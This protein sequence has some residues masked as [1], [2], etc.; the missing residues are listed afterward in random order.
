M[1]RAVR[2]LG[3]PGKESHACGGTVR[4]GI[5]A[6]LR[7]VVQS[8]RNYVSFRGVR[9]VRRGS[10][11]A[12]WTSRGTV[13][14]TERAAAGLGEGG[15]RSRHRHWLAPWLV[16]GACGARDIGGT[17]ESLIPI[18]VSS[19]TASD[20][21]TPGSCQRDDDCRAA[22][23]CVAFS[24]VAGA[25]EARTLSCDDG[26]PCTEDT[27]DP[28]TGCHH[29]LLTEDLDGDG[30]RGPLAGMAAGVPGSCGD[31][32]DDRSS[33]TYPGAPELCDG[34]DND[35]NGIAD[36]GR[37]LALQGDEPLWLSSDS[38][39]AA[40]S[41]ITH[42]GKQFVVALS[43]YR[44][45]NE[46]ELVAVA[47][48]QVN[49]RSAAVRTNSDSYPGSI[50]WTGQHLALAWE[51]RR[52][53]DFEIYFNRFDTAGQKLGPDQRLSHARGFSLAPDLL[54][55]GEGYFVA[56][57][58]RRLGADDFRVFGQTVEL[59]GLRSGEQNA[60]LTP[61]TPGASD[62]RLARG[63]TTSG[64]L[65]HRTEV[66]GGQ[67]LFQMLDEELEPLGAPRALSGPHGVTSALTYKD[68]RYYAFWYDYEVVPG[69]AI[70]GAILSE[71]GHL[72]MPGRRLTTAASFARYASVALLGERWILAWSE[73]QGDRFGVHIQSFD[74]SL[75]P[76]GEVVAL[77]H[78]TGDLDGPQIAASPQG[79]IAVAFTNRSGGQAQ[80]HLVTL[81]CRDPH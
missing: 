66:Q 74:Q 39:R 20:L 9:G 45:R 75:N 23:R 8:V 6:W 43:A 3:P 38:T 35:C 15:P 49:W 70:W 1:G 29:R 54:F 55:T 33:A 77:R 37:A 47:D 60:L 63:E 18:A 65:F 62:P 31:D 12:L 4:P 68:G 59:D 81:G 24:C 25:C 67:V 5:C 16:L 19:A 2:R 80:A 56:W 53:D 73:Y 41:G 76:V 11:V 79:E 71:G 21:A 48:G 36:D 58:D 27:C 78:E 72:L 10:C 52:D 14:V 32:C 34:V 7:T 13:S 22:N 26:D 30:Y 46:T 17:S 51:D 50:I 40:V 42:D 44:A 57:A 28:D 64:L 69:D 61:Q